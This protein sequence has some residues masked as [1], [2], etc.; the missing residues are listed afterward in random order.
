MNKINLSI[1]GALYVLGYQK[2]LMVF[3]CKIKDIVSI[4]TNN[5]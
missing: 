1:T 2:V 3:S 4:F 5:Y